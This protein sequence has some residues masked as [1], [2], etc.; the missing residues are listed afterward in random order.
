MASPLH[1]GAAKVRATSV[2]AQA[3]EMDCHLI[4]TTLEQQCHVDVLARVV[5]SAE[6]LPAV[7]AQQ[8]DFVM[9][10][11]RL[12]D[13]P[14]AG[15]SAAKM[16]Q[17]AGTHCK[18]IILLDTSDPALVIE[19]FRCG[20]RGVFTQ[21]D[22]ANHLA[23]CV[24]AVLRGE[25]WATS[26]QLGYVIDAFSRTSGS[27]HKHSQALQ[28]LTKREA[29]VLQLMAAGLTNREIA[30]QLK[31]NQNTVKNYASDIFQKLGLTSRIEVVLRY[32]SRQQDISTFELPD[33]SAKKFGT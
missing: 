2:V 12:Q 8:P 26:A 5:N 32:F 4:A 10:S 7:V 16:L 33:E 19:S 13:G 18:I 6:V 25:I 17:S 20:A 3:T 15:L 21:E 23:R 31:L 22:S 30:E 28:T 14:F 1:K 24:S 27:L 11:V 29:E 9:I